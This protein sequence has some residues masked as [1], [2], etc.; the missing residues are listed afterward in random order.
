MLASVYMAV[1]S[2][3]FAAAVGRSLPTAVGAN[4]WL[5]VL[6]LLVIAAVLFGIATV[7]QRFLMPGR[8]T[9]FSIGYFW[10]GIAVSLINSI[11]GLTT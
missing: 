11:V 2:L 1:A 10:T 5:M 7:L 3:Q 4:G 8:R 6:V 9:A